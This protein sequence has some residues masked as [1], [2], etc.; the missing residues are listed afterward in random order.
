MHWVINRKHLKIK[1]DFHEW[2]VMSFGLS[3]AP[4]TFM[5]LMNHGSW[6]L[7]G[8]FILVYFDDILSYSKMLDGHVIV[9][10]KIFHVLPKE[11]LYAIFFSPRSLFS[12]DMLYMALKTVKLK[13]S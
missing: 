4:S 8:K 3:N 5:R 2:L 6:K 7:M 1:P 12:C 9:A 13:F 11:K 10:A